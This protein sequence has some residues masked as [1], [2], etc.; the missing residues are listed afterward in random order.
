[1]KPYQ[2]LLIV[3]TA[4]FGILF[5]LEAPKNYT[6]KTI[7]TAGFNPTAQDDSTF[8]ADWDYHSIPTIDS[9]NPEVFLLVVEALKKKNYLSYIGTADDVTMALQHYQRENGLIIFVNRL[10]VNSGK[11]CPKTAKALGIAIY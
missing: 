8:L 6:I 5:A 11:L 2:V 9:D 7:E 3:I 1:M 4:V 10:P